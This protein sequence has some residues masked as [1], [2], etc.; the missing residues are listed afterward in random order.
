M[1]VQRRRTITMGAA[2]FALLIAVPACSSSRSESDTGPGQATSA[3]A[4]ATGAASAA[5]F[6][7]LTSPCGK[8]DAKGATDQGVTDSSISIGY[9]DDRGFASQPGLNKE[10]GDAVKGMIK[11]CNDR[12]GING[13][14]LNGN[15]Y[16]AAITQVNTA[17]TK[18]CKSDFMLVGEGWAGDEGS[19]QTRIACKLPAVPAYTVGPDFANAPMMY[20]AIPNPVDYQPA[21]GWYQMTKQFPDVTSGAG[22]MNATLPAIQATIA[23]QMPTAQAAG[24]KTLDCGVT[25]NYTGEPNYVPF[26]QKFKDCGA[27][28][29]YAPTP[30]PQLN[31]MLAAMNQVGARPKYLMQA[32]GYTTDFAQ[33][34]G[35]GL[36]DDVY[37]QAATQPL[38]NAGAVPAVKQYVDVVAAVQGKTGVLGEQATSSFLLWANAAKTC[39][40]TLTRQ[41]MV[42]N[43]AK[44]HDWTGGGLHA[45]TDPGGNLPPSCGMLLKLDKTTWTQAFPTKQAELQCDP[46]YRF[47]TPAS[48]YGATLNP[49][50]IAT[51]FLT[52]DVIK[53]QA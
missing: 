10:I 38:E 27:K 17:M 14:T 41:C 33:S 49:D 19:E 37:V 13:R 47:K 8:G 42:N 5:N 52:P 53:P 29:V 11:W 46:A 31:G 50:R 36:A 21:S 28:I 40:S 6:G 20:Q 2:V 3:N 32:N 26:A 9:G 23:K 30:G 35:A 4:A 22:F 7:T 18:A 12:G 16:D 15:F 39:G 51:R 44:T 34:N 1:I 25:L 24:Y 43:L 48:T 45:S